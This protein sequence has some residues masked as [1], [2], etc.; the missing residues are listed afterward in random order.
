MKVNSPLAD[1][2]GFEGQRVIN[3]E[4]VSCPRQ[5]GIKPLTFQLVGDLSCELQ[6]PRTYMVNGGQGSEARM[7]SATHCTR[8]C[9]TLEKEGHSGPQKHHHRATLLSILNV[10]G[11]VTFH[12]VPRQNFDVRPH[13]LQWSC[14]R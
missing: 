5:S 4:L 11:T 10:E 3:L 2:G 9:W 6:T 14:D 12:L 1:A 8:E 7:K 13:L